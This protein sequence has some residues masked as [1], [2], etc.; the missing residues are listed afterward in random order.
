MGDGSFLEHPSAQSLEVDLLRFNR[1]GMLAELMFASLFFV[2]PEL[3][4]H[5][6]EAW[7]R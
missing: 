4:V 3:C 7:G 6:A 2:P 1:R 5:V